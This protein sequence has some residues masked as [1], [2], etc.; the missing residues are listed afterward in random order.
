MGEE[1]EAKA[2][3]EVAEGAEE[4]ELNASPAPEAAVG[5]GVDGG[6]VG[7]RAKALEGE[8][9][10]AKDRYLRLAADF[11]NYRKRAIRD[12]ADFEAQSNASMVQD[13]L[14]VMDNMERALAAGR[15]GGEGRLEALL[16]GIDLTIKL[17]KSVLARSGVERI[18]AVGE[19]FNPDVHE[20]IQQGESPEVSVDTVAEELEAGYTMRGKVLRAARVRVLKPCAA[21]GDG[22]GKKEDAELVTA[23]AAAT[24]DK[25]T[26]WH[27]P[28][29]DKKKRKTPLAERSREGEEPGY[30]CHG[31]GASFGRLTVE[32]S[33]VLQRKDQETTGQL[34][35]PLFP[36]SR[37]GV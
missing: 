14:P 30:F 13:I 8:L 11:D 16:K 10:E 28:L 6:G 24:G 29:C 23:D 1:E 20:A 9:A 3:A 18:K 26:E 37:L 15:E 17:F 2:V 5:E 32:G 4:A 36:V 35:G 33:D 19:P 27:C 22:D 25:K 31:C 7:A 12:R 21:A 34:I